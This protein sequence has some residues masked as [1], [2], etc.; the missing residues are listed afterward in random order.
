MPRSLTLLLLLSLLLLSGCASTVVTT[1][2][3]EAIQLE[4]IPPIKALQDCRGLEKGS[5]RLP[6]AVVVTGFS[7]EPQHGSADLPDYQLHFG[8][9]LKERLLETGQF[10]VR[11]ALHLRLTPRN[12]APNGVDDVDNRQQIQ[13]LA[14]EFNAQLVVGG[15]VLDTRLK[16]AK[17]L[18]REHNRHLSVR[19]DIYDG[20]SGLLLQSFINGVE[21]SDTEAN[22]VFPLLEHGFYRTL[23]GQGSDLLLASH[24]EQTQII[25]S[26]LPL[27]AHLIVQDQNSVVLKLGMRSGLKPGDRFSL[28]HGIEVDVDPKGNSLYE[29][30]AVADF[31]VTN[32]QPDLTF[33]RLDSVN[34]HYLLDRYGY[35]I[36][37]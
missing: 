25:S 20:F 4:L 2:G 16:P 14:R 26:C 24:L 37:W 23:T 3:A 32:V 6:K 34:S 30:R 15:E 9:A 5:A 36:G 10:L 13:S 17:G 19:Y 31:I 21:I 1:Y 28:I 22:T 18:F 33:G 11:D 29:Y 27:M 7:M 12:L 35:A 8:R